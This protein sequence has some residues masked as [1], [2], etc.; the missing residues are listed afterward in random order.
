MPAIKGDV[1]QLEAISPT[2]NHDTASIPLVINTKPTI[3]P[4]IECVVKLASH[5]YLQYRAKNPLPTKM[6]SY[7]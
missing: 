1:I 3:A 5:Y 4:T 2:V 6:T 7:L